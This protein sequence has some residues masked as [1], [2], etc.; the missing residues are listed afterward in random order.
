[1]TPVLYY[2]RHGQT[3]WNMEGRLQGQHDSE[4]NTT[5]LAQALTC[6]S[7]LAD[8]LARE[9]KALEHFDY[10]SSPLGRARN[11]MEVMRA[12][13]GLVPEQY[14]VEPRLAEIGFGRWEGLTLADIRACES[15]AWTA[16]EH[17]K[18]NFVPPDGESYA[19]VAARVG[20]WYA[21]LTRDSVVTAH[22]GTARALIA[23]LGI[24]PPEQAANTDISQGVVYV[25]AKN[26]F[27]RYG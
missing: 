10:V 23:H 20:A 19:Q 11:M 26:S 22:G 7:I 1:M 18:W 12:T 21:E 6:G 17:D 15:D 9:G 5:G 16:R 27:A 13:L 2:V 3:I 8:L 25:F 4:L 14:G 24:A